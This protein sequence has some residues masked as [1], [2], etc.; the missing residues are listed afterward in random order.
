MQFRAKAQK[1]REREGGGEGER[2][3]SG[4]TKSIKKPRKLWFLACNDGGGGERAPTLCLES[5]IR[6]LG[7]FLESH[8]QRKRE[9]ERERER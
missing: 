4:R 7:T 8:L 1:E 9:R 5:L 2:S 6:G 3:K